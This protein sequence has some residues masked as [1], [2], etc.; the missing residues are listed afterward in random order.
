[1]ITRQEYVN[2]F[3]ELISLERKEEMNRH[4]EEIKR[5]S[6]KVREKKGRAL[7]FM[8]GKLEGTTIGG[9]H[10]VKFTKMDNGVEIIDSEI[11]V[12]DLIIV[13]NGYPLKKGNFTG[14]VIEKS[15]YALTVVFD[16][17]PNK[18]FI[19]KNIRL[20]LY[21]NDTTFQMMLD[22]L[23]IIKNK[24]EVST[25]LIEKI[26]GNEKL[27]N[28][29]NYRNL[30]I[31]DIADK[32]N[33]IFLLHG[34]PGTGKTS[35]CIDILVDSVKKYENILATADSNTA[36]D[37]IVYRL[38]YKGINV[39]RIGH[40][41]RVNKVL[42][43]HTLDYLLMDHKRYEEVKFLRDSAFKELEL[44]EK[45]IYPSKKYTRGMS[46]DEIL[47]QAEH[48]K[49]TRGVSKEIISNMAEYI[50]K[51]REI[52]EIFDR[53]A[54]LEKD[55]IEEI[56][57]KADVI[58]TTNVGAGSK[59]IK[60][61]EFDLLL[62][63]EASQATETSALI[64]IIKSKKVIFAGDHKQ[65]P[66]VVMNDLAAKKGYNISMFE[67]LIED[68]GNKNS[69]MLNLQYRMNEK[70]AGFS[71]EMFY[72]GKLKT[73]RKNKNRILD[74]PRRIAK[75]YM[76]ALNP[77]KPIVFINVDRGKEKRIGRGSSIYNEE[78]A[79]YVIDYVNKFIEYGIDEGQI[80]VI[81]PYKAQSEYIK[82]RIFNANIEVDTVD[83]FQ[84]RGKD[85][86]ILSLV[87]SNDEKEIGF[88][89]DYRRLNV[90]LT[91]ARKKLII[92]G[93]KSTIESE[94][95]FKRLLDYCKRVYY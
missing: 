88:L 52:D 95:L 57:S 58:C 76:Y 47:K 34:P 43:E 64:P 70:I 75:E 56:L 27:D 84:G 28:I 5:L 2:K 45:F 77:S 39:I 10:I 50:N 36:V 51:R 91:R 12:G 1:L 6:G 71:S 18:V 73:A 68:F 13:S 94:Y 93:D 32:V 16:K 9:R 14:T 92:I 22:T 31:L 46:D 85:V 69:Y 40:P 17:A 24:A 81:T 66:P 62:M 38:A 33:D 11:N 42:R 7:L 3:N 63:D 23:N 15:K 53:A 78:E 67:R 44:L 65:L 90:S 83:S 60:D 55:I 80:G 35:V 8:R 26:L 79:K 29:F 4:I 25:D 82:E 21:V 59:F 41:Y 74:V 49:G 61:Y 19:S 89:K 37:N 20:D 72:D 30:N 86:I 54:K 87:R 48:N